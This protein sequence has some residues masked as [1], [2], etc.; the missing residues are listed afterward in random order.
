MDEKLALEM[1]Y[2]NGYEQGVKDFAERMKNVFGYGWLLGSSVKNQIDN[3]V[4]EIY[5]S[6]RN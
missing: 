5:T 4:K 3:L 2:K 1:A 6:T